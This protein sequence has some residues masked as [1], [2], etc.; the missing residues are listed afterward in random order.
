MLLKIR[1]KGKE[2]YCENVKNTTLAL[3]FFVCDPDW[4]YFNLF[5]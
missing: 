4:Q 3:S 1:E 2:G 5:G